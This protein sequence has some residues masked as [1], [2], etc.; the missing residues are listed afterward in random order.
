MNNGKRPAKHD[1]HKAMLIV[2]G[3]GIDW[4]GHAKDVTEDY[5]LMLLI[6]AIQSQTLRFAKV[7]R[8]HAVPPPMIGNYMPSKSDLGIDES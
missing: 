6:P 5:A 4:T 7:K 8:M 3:E 1:E 2:D